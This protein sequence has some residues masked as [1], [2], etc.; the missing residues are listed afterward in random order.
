MSDDTEPKTAT[1][2]MAE[3]VA[4]RKAATVSGPSGQQGRKATERA[5]AAHANSKWKP[6]PRKA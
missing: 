3:L 2:T 1:Q 4:K 6:A 5:A